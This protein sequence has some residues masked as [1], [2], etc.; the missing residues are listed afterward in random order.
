MAELSV[1]GSRRTV[2]ADPETPLLWVLR[3]D[4]KLKGSK[5]GCGVG[6]CGAC[7]VMIDGNAMPSCITSIADASGKIVTTIE[8]LEGPIV[9]IVRDEWIKREVAQCGYCQSGQIVAAVALLT[10]NAS[11]SDDD[12]DAAM[13][14]HICRCCTY[15]RIRAAIYAARDRLKT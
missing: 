7:A 14:Q 2:A 11:P 1:N 12:I 13:D 15:G 10:A 9:E 5:F 3:D 8:G 6:I 4:L